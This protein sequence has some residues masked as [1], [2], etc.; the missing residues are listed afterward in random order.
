M[1]SDTPGGAGSGV[2]CG[3]TGAGGSVVAVHRSRRSALSATTPRLLLLSSA[4]ALVL[5]AC[6]G[7]DAAPDAATPARRTV[8]IA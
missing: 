2:E 4:V 5:S 7:K 8:V 3:H 1:T 6:G